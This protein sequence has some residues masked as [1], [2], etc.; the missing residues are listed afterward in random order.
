M[1]CTTKRQLGLGVAPSVRS[2]A[3][4]DGLA[5]SPRVSLACH[6]VIRYEIAFRLA[7]CQACLL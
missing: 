6:R 2:H 7:G 5:G 1:H 4:A 3:C